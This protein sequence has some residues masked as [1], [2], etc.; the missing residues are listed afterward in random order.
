MTASASHAIEQSLA[1]QQPPDRPPPTAIASPCT[2]GVLS[3]IRAHQP[4]VSVC[5]LR[6]CRVAHSVLSASLFALCLVSAAEQTEQQT[7]L[8]RTED[9]LSR[10]RLL[11]RCCR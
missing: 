9:E 7:P 3:V 1:R 2:V 4:T 10:T 8:A 5:L 11:R 6:H